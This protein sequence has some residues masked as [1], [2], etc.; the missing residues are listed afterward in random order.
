MTDTFFKND[1]AC[2][3]LGIPDPPHHGLLS[4]VYDQLKDG[5]T[6]VAVDRRNCIVGACINAAVSDWTEDNNRQFAECCVP[7]PEKDLLIFYDHLRKRPKLFEKYCATKVFSCNFLAV[8]SQWQKLGVAKTLVK[9]SWYMAAEL[10][11]DIFR[12]DCT[13]R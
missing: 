9:R 12:F 3:Y 6:L 13:N 7:R 2:V 5:M 11:F 1:P 10:G 4:H 8:D